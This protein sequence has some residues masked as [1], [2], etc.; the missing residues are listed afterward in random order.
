[1]QAEE[2]ESSETRICSFAKCGG[3]RII[4][5]GKCKWCGERLLM[6]DSDHGG[7]GHITGKHRM[8]DCKSAP[9]GA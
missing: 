4:Y 8:Y 7:R 6:C 1:M 9:Y 2:H 5:E 3:T